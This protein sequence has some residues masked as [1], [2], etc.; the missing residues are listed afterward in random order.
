MSGIVGFI[1]QRADAAE[2][3][4]E[5]CKRIAHRGPDGVGCYHNGPFALGHRRLH[6]S[7]T[8]EVQP[9]CSEDE[10]FA[11]ALDGEIYN[12]AA[13]QTQLEQAGYHFS[14]NPGPAEVLLHGYQAW[15]EEVLEKLRGMFAFA[16]WDAQ[17]Q[18]LFCARDPFGIKPLYYYQNEE[19]ELLFGS[20][21][22]SFL[23]HPGFHKALNENQ[24][25]LYLSFQY[26]PG[27]DTFF[28]SVKKLLPGHWLRWQAGG[29]TVQSY[30]QPSFAPQQLYSRTDWEHK[31]EET[32]Q[33][34]VEIQKAQLGSVG[35][36]LSSGVD[37]S[38]LASLS[39]SKRTYTAGFVNNL[40]DETAGAAEFS[41]I[42]GAQ[43]R[44]RTI[45]PEEYWEELPRIQYYMDEPLADA[46]AAAFY[47]VS[48]EAA[49]QDRVCFSGEGADE[50]FAGYNIYQEPFTALWYE[51][52][53]ASV[54]YTLG[55]AAE[56]MPPVKGRNFLVRRA[57]SLPERYIGPT[58]LMGETEKKRLLR[59]YQGTV[60][61]TD[62]TRPYLEQSVG[63]DPV[64]R[65]Q[66]ID[67]NLWLAG[68]ILLQA[69]KMSMASSLEV[70][71]P[72]LDQEVFQLAR[73]IP[74]QYRVD[75]NGTKQ[76]FRGAAASR[77]P[78]SVTTKKKLGFP[79][80]VRAWLREEPYISQVRE[81][82]QSPAAQQFFHTHMLMR[83]LDQ[84]VSGRRDN[85]RQIWCVYVFLVWYAEYFEKR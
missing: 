40:Y 12:A 74:V 72:F 45:D 73:R 83:L 9:L 6:V 69:D 78:R 11:V 65:M 10:R 34:S 79:V 18:S 63:Q 42:L 7:Q 35:S 60:L 32:L 2:I 51:K 1:G 30:W 33:Q 48:R 49:Q 55:R 52:L 59:Q 70:R 80:P 53:P 26:S 64:T 5:M 21:I 16:L 15:G 23:P 3:L 22:K 77:L 17:T 31:I 68:D 24:L 81:A 8:A 29:Y 75:A 25:E 41:K 14:P 76:A 71:T 62:L 20:E 47:F 43:H 37:S 54:R 19:G 57:V 46:A 84:H 36:F 44:V 50:L 39:E 58:D 67:M 56:Q 66:L 13:L 4:D 61:P 27:E 28:Q 85:W 82:F 38:Y